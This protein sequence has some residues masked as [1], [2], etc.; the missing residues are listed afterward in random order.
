MERHDAAVR[1]GC[2]GGKICTTAQ[3]WVPPPEEAHQPARSGRV[4]KNTPTMAIIASLDVDVV[5]HFISVRLAE[6]KK[7]HVKHSTT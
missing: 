2:S 7:Q 4:R 3:L 1:H 6:K 5:P